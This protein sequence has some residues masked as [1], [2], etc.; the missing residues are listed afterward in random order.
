MIIGHVS[1]DAGLRRFIFSFHMMAFM[2][3]SGY[4]Y[5]ETDEI[6]LKRIWKRNKRLIIPLAVFS[7]I[8]IYINNFGIIEE[9][10]TLLL[11]MS[12]S[13]KNID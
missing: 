4:L 8:F 5:K 1:I 2:V 9:L 12:L 11:G 6:V 10:K 13:R 7:I 3:L